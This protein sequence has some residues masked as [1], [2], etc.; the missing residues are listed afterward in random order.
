MVE[1]QDKVI[2]HS[3][4]GKCGCGKDLEE[5]EVLRIDRKT[6]VLFTGEVV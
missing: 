1:N 3:V 2:L 4:K 6:G 5:V